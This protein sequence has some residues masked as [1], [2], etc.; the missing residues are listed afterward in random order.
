[1]KNQF[2]AAILVII[3]LLGVSANSVAYGQII[4]PQQPPTDTVKPVQTLN[5]NPNSNNNIQ[6]ASIDL[7]NPIGSGQNLQSN[8]LINCPTGVV[9]Y[10][11]SLI[12]NEIVPICVTS[13][14]LNSQLFKIDVEVKDDNKDNDNGDDGNDH[15]KKHFKHY[16]VYYN[17]NFWNH[18]WSNTHP[19]KINN[20]KVVLTDPRDDP[21]YDSIDWRSDDGKSD[22]SIQEMDKILEDQQNKKGDTDNKGYQPIKTT[23]TTAPAPAPAP[24]VAVAP[25]SNQNIDT[26]ASDNGDSIES[27]QSTESGSESGSSSD[28]DG[29]DSGSSDGSGDS[30]GGGNGGD[31]GSDG[32]DSGGSEGG[33]N[34]SDEGGEDNN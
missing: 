23:F 29:G 8:F 28:S 32:G 18:Y 34:G 13:D 9:V 2:S 15:H 27:Q 6:L 17:K 33:D 19:G 20:D 5:P 12:T 21:K 7:N 24:S 26:I 3:V 22:L 14:M 1:M 25:T 11:P 31:N 30:N 16:P 4:T 10:Q